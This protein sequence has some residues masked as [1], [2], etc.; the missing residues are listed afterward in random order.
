MAVAAPGVRDL[1]A[2]EGFAGRRLS[3]GWLSEGGGHWIQQER[4]DEVNQALLRFLADEYP[5]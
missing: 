4:P 2:G 5:T 3:Q 1:L